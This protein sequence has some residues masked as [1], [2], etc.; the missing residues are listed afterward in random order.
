MYY[1][2]WTHCVFQIIG[3]VTGHLQAKQEKYIIQ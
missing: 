2:M 3:A 1:V